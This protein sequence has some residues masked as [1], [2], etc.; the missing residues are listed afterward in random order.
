MTFKI[1]V[2]PGDH[3]EGVASLIAEAMPDGGTMVLTGGTT[4]ER[5]YPRLAGKRADWSNVGFAFSD[6]R[7][8]PPDD[9]ASNYGMAKRL[10][11]DAAAAQTSDFGRVQE[12]WTALQ[13]WAAESRLAADQCARQTN[14]ASDVRSFSPR[15]R[16][17]SERSTPQPPM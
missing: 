9:A 13:G 5:V 4:A 6:E 2:L 15:T 8:V 1:D 17:H 12:R 14:N 16:S 11:L 10:F 7:C 3:A